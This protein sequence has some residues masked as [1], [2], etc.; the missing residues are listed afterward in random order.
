VIVNLCLRFVGALLINALLIVP[1]A[2]AINVT[3]NLRQLFWLTIGLSLLVPFIGQ[4]ISWEAEVRFKTPFGISGTIV[5][6]SVGVFM[7]SMLVGP[8]VRS[9][10]IAS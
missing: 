5:L 6:V 1:A 9:R 2:A 4:W 7:L 3:R 10:K 8:W